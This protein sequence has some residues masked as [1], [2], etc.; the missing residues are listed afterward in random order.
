M[1]ADKIK[2]LRSQKGLSQEGLAKALYLTQQSVSR[3]E[4]GKSYPDLPTLQALADYFGVKID[5]L[6]GSEEYSSA[7]AE[8]KVHSSPALALILWGAGVVLALNL[9][10]LLAFFAFPSEVPQ[11]ISY[12]ETGYLA[13]TGGLLALLIVLYKKGSKKLILG[14]LIGFA[15]LGAFALGAFV[16]GIYALGPTPYLVWFTLLISLVCLATAGFFLFALLHGL[17]ALGETR[18]TSQVNPRD[19]TGRWAKIYSIMTILVSVLSVLA[20][21]FSWLCASKSSTV[22]RGEADGF[23]DLSAAWLFGMLLVTCIILG[24]VAIV[25]LWIATKKTKRHPVLPIVAIVVLASASTAPF[26]SDH[27]AQ[28][29]AA[30]AN[31]Y[32]TE[33]WLAASPEQRYAMWPSFAKDHT[34]VGQSETWV[35]TNLGQADR[36]AN[37]TDWIY[38]MGNETNPEN[39]YLKIT[40]GI[41]K[42]VSV[43][44]IYRG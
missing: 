8:S 42:L 22:T 35:V 21:L 9:I 18:E 38:N 7:K 30:D 20:I 23:I 28:Q 19:P 3:W 32:T 1:F 12:A 39:F 10:L 17:P 6:V 26:I 24:I 14:G 34:V 5:D 13:L 43:Y 11:W 29:S 25:F 37:T 15:F 33:K 36:I 16:M 2:T 40:F 4:T 41:D 44:G 27:Y 31:A